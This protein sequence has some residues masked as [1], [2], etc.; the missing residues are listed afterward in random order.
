MD[1]EE[2]AK[3]VDSAPVNAVE[4][5]MAVAFECGVSLSEFWLMTSYELLQVMKSV[6]RLSKRDRKKEL[7]DVWLGAAW[8][9][10]G[11][12]GFPSLESVHDAVDGKGLK[13]NE[14]IG[15]SVKR[16]FDYPGDE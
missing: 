14:E 1:P 13:S 7:T 15:E 8:G 6:E 5:S 9:R 12:D 11:K 3:K 10:T 4:M 16:Y 2:S